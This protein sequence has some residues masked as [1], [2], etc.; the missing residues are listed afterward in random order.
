MSVIIR[1]F[2]VRISIELSI[3]GIVEIHRKYLLA[4]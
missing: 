4:I 3:T 1:M 2:T